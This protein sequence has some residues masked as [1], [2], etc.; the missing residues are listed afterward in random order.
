MGDAGYHKDPITAQGIS[1]AFRDAD[2]LAEA[3]DDGLSGRRRL[4]DA[5]AGYERRRNEAVRPI[6]EMTY[7]FAARGSEFTQR[8][9][10]SSPAGNIS[11]PSIPAVECAD[12]LDDE[13][14]APVMRS[15]GV[16]ASQL[17]ARLAEQARRLCDRGAV[18]RSKARR[19]CRSEPLRPTSRRR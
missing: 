15:A 17:K 3:V 16:D 10:I 2:L 13:I 1:D 6:Y 18:P 4:D 7:Q 12:L 8:R 5:L 9:S 14:M 19:T 11:N